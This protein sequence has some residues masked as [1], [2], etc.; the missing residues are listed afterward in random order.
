MLH[1][2]RLLGIKTA[3]QTFRIRQAT[4]A[5]RAGRSPFRRRNSCV[6]FSGLMI[7]DL[8]KQVHGRFPFEKYF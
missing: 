5:R 7:E 8:V 2:P 6:S 4:P 1:G 3:Q